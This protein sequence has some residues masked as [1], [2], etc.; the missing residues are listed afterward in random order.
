MII[1]NNT[2]QGAI[3]IAYLFGA[4]RIVLLGYD[5]RMVA[6]QHNWHSKHKG[7]TSHKRYSDVFGPAI[8][9]AAKVL[10]E[11]GVEVINCAAG[12]ALKCFPYI[13]LREIDK[14]PEV[15][16]PEIVEPEAELVAFL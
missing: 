1:A 8:T 16:Q 3:N 2:G 11:K 13:P 4:K 10:K 6:G 12:S 9:K 14:G 7:A 15:I 5:M